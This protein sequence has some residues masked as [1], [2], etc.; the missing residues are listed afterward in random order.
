MSI[1]LK[2][3]MN[4]TP[5]EEPDHN[6]TEMD[7]LRNELQDR[8]MDI[9]NEELLERDIEILRE[10]LHKSQNP[11]MRVPTQSSHNETN[12]ESAGESESDQIVFFIHDEH[13]SKCPEVEIRFKN[14]ITL[15]SITDSGSEV[16][17]ISM[18]AFELIQT[19]KDIPTLPV[20]NVRLV[21]ASGRR[22][23]KIKT[24]AL[25]EFTLGED[26]FESIFL[27][28]PQLTHD[29]I[30]GC[31]LLKEHGMSINFEEEH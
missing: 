27:I 11:V 6:R 10:A 13:A 25:I 31:Q 5:R 1:G 16:N 29:V 3:N 7:Q 23:N 21:T 24:Q 12:V 19:K 15:R 30:L 14:D 18:K 8:C 4:P 26:E 17:I 28:S 22:S 9:N 20:E 2:S